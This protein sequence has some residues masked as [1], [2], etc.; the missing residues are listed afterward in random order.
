[1]DFCGSCR[2]GCSYLILSPAQY[3]GPLHHRTLEFSHYF[4]GVRTSQA[5]T[6]LSNHSLLWNHWSP[7]KRWSKREVTG[8]FFVP[9]F[10]MPGPLWEDLRMQERWSSV[11]ILQR[12]G[13]PWGRDMTDGSVPASSCS[14]QTGA[15]TA[16]V[17][18]LPCH[19]HQTVTH[20][21]ESQLT[22]VFACIHVYVYLYIHACMFM[23]V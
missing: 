9:Y 14:A 17:K 7:W 16:P 23:H 19:L 18:L 4:L 1:M 10:Q 22:S 11:S 12:L 15:S 3:K 8:Y 13:R 21:Q 20:V 2:Q 5:H 6:P